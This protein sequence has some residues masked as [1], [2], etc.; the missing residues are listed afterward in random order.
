[1]TER[2]ETRLVSRLGYGVATLGVVIAVLLVLVYR[3]YDNYDESNTLTLHTEEVQNA[4]STMRA[5]MY[6]AESLVRAYYLSDRAVY[7]ERSRDAANAAT[8]TLERV[9]RLTKDNDL[10]RSRVPLLRAAFDRRMEARD[11][12][13]VVMAQGGSPSST[14]AGSSTRSSAR[15]PRRAVLAESA[16]ATILVIE[17]NAM[18]MKLITFL[19]TQAGH[20]VVAHVTASEGL[21]A[22][23]HGALPDL[24]LM[25]VQLPDFDGLTATRRIRERP[26]ARS[27]PIIAVTA[28]AMRGDEERAREAGC[29]GYLTKPIRYQALL[30][31]VSR[32]VPA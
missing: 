23:E 8:A 18:N 30:D 11:R 3:S 31:V 17:D 10:Q 21:D 4:L 25:D 32:F 2:S 12:M 9:R 26:R 19:L 7:L 28:F 27:I 14:T 24:I 22:L 16:M 5:D 15:S 1:M 29:D 6:R 20:H 13:L